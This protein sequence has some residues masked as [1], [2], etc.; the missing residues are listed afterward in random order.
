MKQTLS[1]RCTYTMMH[2][3][4]CERVSQTCLEA[5]HLGAVLLPLSLSRGWNVEPHLHQTL[6]SLLTLVE[7]QSHLILA[8]GHLNGRWRE[9]M[10]GEGI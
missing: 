10:R 1:Y 6:S 7:L 5:V 4:K 2:H 9:G 8:R 3:N